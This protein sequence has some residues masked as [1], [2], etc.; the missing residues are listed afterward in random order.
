[1][2]GPGRGVSRRISGSLLAT[3][4]RGGMIRRSAIACLLASVLGGT[5]GFAAEP[6]FKLSRPGEE[7]F[8]LSVAAVGDLNADGTADFAV[9]APGAGKVIVFDGASLA[10]LFSL[11]GPGAAAYFGRFVAP[12]GD[13]DGDGTPDLIAAAPGTSSVMSP[14]GYL[15]IIS[16]ASRQEIWRATGQTSARSF[17]TAAAVIGDVNGDGRPDVLVGEPGTEGA[18]PGAAY[19]FSGALDGP[20]SPPDLLFVHDDSPPGANLGRAVAATGDL[21]GDGVPDYVLGAPN[22]GTSEKQMPL[23]RVVVVSGATGSPLQIIDGR[24]WKYQKRTYPQ[25]LGHSLGSIA[26]LDGDGVREIVIG[27]NGFARILSGRTREIVQQVLH[28][29]GAGLFGRGITSLPDITGDGVDELVLG[30]DDFVGV[31]SVVGLIPVMHFAWQADP[32]EL[33]GYANAAV[34]RLLLAGTWGTNSVKGF[35]PIARAS[36]LDVMAL[37]AAAWFGAPGGGSTGAP[38]GRFSISIKKAVVQLLLDVRGLSADGTYR[39]FLFDGAGLDTCREVATVEVVGGAARLDLAPG[40][41]IPPG[42]GIGSLAELSGRRLE[43]RNIHGAVALVAHVP[44]LESLRRT[45][46]GGALTPAVGSPLPAAAGTVSFTDDPV[47]GMSKFTLKVKGVPS[48][49][50]AVLWV[51]DAPGSGVFTEYGELP[52][53][54]LT[55]D[56][57]RGDLLPM[58]VPR[59]ADL[60]RLRMGVRWQ[61]AS[62]LEWTPGPPPGPRPDFVVTRIRLSRFFGEQL[63]VR[64]HISNVGSADAGQVWLRV[65]VKFPN[66]SI[67]RAATRT[68]VA[69]PAQTSLENLELAL[70]DMTGDDDLVAVR[71]DVDRDTSTTR[72]EFDEESEENN[73]RWTEFTWNSGDQDYD[74]TLDMTSACPFE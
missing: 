41:V 63:R 21:D 50:P 19:V 46:F 53:G 16:G 72:G 44:F 7:D 6:V 31:Y 25:V 22:T 47:K 56:G 73:M 58:G 12:A 3:G 17:G 29:Q 27:A 59:V 74:R 52:G 1:M 10:E 40:G 38:S 8:G 51:E 32:A 66:G 55:L 37:R 9:G 42:L 23:G 26:D 45:K 61:T 64:A 54:T 69:C 18:S 30:A 62:I 39:L 33:A 28:P 70:F 2:I 49:T 14:P 36:D 15:S 11:T 48:D 43:L 34:G 35:M 13:F 24:T 68:T 60:S 67:Q 57:K 20:G 4:R 5:A 71:V 65:A